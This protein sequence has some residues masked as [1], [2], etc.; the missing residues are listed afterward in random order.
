MK[1]LFSSLMASHKSSPKR[2]DSQSRSRQSQPRVEGLEQKALMTYILPGGQ[3]LVGNPS[4]G[5]PLP[6]L[7]TAMGAITANR[8]EP[9][10]KDGETEWVKGESYHSLAENLWSQAYSIAVDNRDVQGQLNVANAWAAYTSDGYMASADYAQALGEAYYWA[11]P[12]YGTGSG[13]S[14]RYGYDEIIAV[15][16]DYGTLKAA[17]SG[18]SSN[19]SYVES[20]YANAENAYDTSYLSLNKLMDQNTPSV[21]GGTWDAD[22]GGVNVIFTINQYAGAS[23]GTFTTSLG[24]EGSVSGS[25]FTI[26]PHGSNGWYYG[27]FEATYNDGTGSPMV[28]YASISI[29]ASNHMELSLWNGRQYLAYDAYRVY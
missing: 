16:N 24:K 14:F 28:G 13:S 9:L 15:I 26:L 12:D 25:G 29:D 3:Q 22:I 10:I 19:D 21:L 20:I 11:Y 5:T 17:L 23:T 2:G 4:P 6:Q 8:V 18:S 27:Y 7:S 1:N